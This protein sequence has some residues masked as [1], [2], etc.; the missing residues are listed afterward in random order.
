MTDSY[1]SFEQ[2]DYYT[3]LDVP[4]DAGILDI[5]RRYRAALLRVH[6]DKQP[7]L[8]SHD[9]PT[10]A[11]TMISQLQDAFRV[12]S[13]PDLR[14]EYDILLREG[15][16]KFPS[17]KVKQRPANDVSLDEF[18]SEEVVGDDGE[19]TF[20]WTHPCRCGSSFVIKEQELEE[21]IHYIGC[22]G[23]SEVVWVGYEAVEDVVN[24]EENDTDIS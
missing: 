19:V 1:A 17:T 21:G 2:T 23:C 6:P 22:G 18:E 10:S 13:D 16:G 9:S 7:Q 14:A 11:S 24:D 5:R 4:R 8:Q 3:L 15:K 12:L 20:K